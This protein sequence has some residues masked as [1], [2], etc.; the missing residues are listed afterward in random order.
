MAFIMYDK[1]L[2][3]VC[4]IYI[5]INF[6]KIK[7]PLELNLCFGSY[8]LQFLSDFEAFSIKMIKSYS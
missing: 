7:L 3:T 8:Y 5:C 2:I 6:Y 1:D 4:I